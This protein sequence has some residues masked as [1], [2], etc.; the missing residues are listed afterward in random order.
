MS[1]RDSSAPHSAASWQADCITTTLYEAEI[2]TLS[3]KVKLFGEQH[4]FADGKR[5]KALAKGR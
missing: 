4:V 5:C 2:K 3:K 1:V